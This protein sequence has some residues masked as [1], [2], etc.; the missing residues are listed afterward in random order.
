MLARLYVLL[1]YSLALP[2]GES[3]PVYSYED[4][5]YEIRIF[6]PVKSNEPS[7][8]VAD[9]EKLTI[10]DKPGFRANVLRIDFVKDNFDRRT[11][12]DCDP[13]Y[14]LIQRTINS[15]LRKLRFVVRGFQVK[16]ID[17]PR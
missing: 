10:N 16:E 14:D 2:D 6:P 7:L 9:G 1:P 12:I 3:Y 15:F 11:G 8:D 17:F 13:P 4:N 5:G